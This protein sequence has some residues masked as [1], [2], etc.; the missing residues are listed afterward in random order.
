MLIR[1]QDTREH[2]RFLCAEVGTGGV[3]G[4]QETHRSSPALGG[5]ET[6]DETR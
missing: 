1:G 4:F 6:H 5:D 2:L 3:G